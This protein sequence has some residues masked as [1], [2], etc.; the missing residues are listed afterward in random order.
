[1]AA[2][3]DV[4]NRGNKTIDAGLSLIGEL[5]K[6]TGQ[7]LVGDTAALGVGL[8]M[9][10]ARMGIQIETG[11]MVD[12]DMIAA[13]VLPNHLIGSRVKFGDAGWVCTTPAFGLTLHSGGTSGNDAVGGGEMIFRHGSAHHT[14]RATVRYT[15]GYITNQFI[16]WESLGGAA[17]DGTPSAAARIHCD[18]L[19][20]GGKLRL[21]AKFPT[22]GLVVVATEP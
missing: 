21:V 14:N 7:T 6:P 20:A 16:E 8:Y 1:M 17:P 10:G 11:H 22:G 9:N 5:L 4:R 12:A 18:T 13:I 15:G 19:G 2:F 3:M